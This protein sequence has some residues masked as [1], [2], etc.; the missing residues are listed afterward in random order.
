ML[1]DIDYNLYN[2]KRKQ[3]IKL[4]QDDGNKMLVHRNNSHNGIV[5]INNDST[6]FFQIY[7]TDSYNNSSE[8]SFYSNNKNDAVDNSKKIIFNNSNISVIDNVL[9]LKLD[10]NHKDYIEILYDNN[11][12]V[13]NKF[14]I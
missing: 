11:L 5:N 7:I 2:L 10:V 8:L 3:Y 12:I 14:G 1:V 9:E 4:Y 6:H 13:V